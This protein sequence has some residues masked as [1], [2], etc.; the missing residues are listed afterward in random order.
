[1]LSLNALVSFQN[2]AN[3]VPS[4]DAPSTG[5]LQSPD[6]WTSLDGTPIKSGWSF[7]DG[8]IHLSQTSAD[9]T[10]LA[11]GHIITTDEFEDFDLEFE[12]KIGKNGNSG[13][14]YMVQRYDD[15]HLGI[16]YQI[17]DD[18]GLHRVEPKNSTGA[19]YDLYAPVPDKPLKPAGEWNRSRIVVQ[20]SQIQHWLNGRLI[21]TATMHDQEW[22]DRIAASKFHDVPGFCK[23]RRGRLMLTDHGSDAWYRIISFR[24]ASTSKNP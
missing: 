14:K 4:V 8:L 7:Q 9:Q 24:H 12:W 1:M 11:G 22:Q 10:E 15:R 20:N 19:L 5:H 13:I 3:T 23:S 6:H 21:A 17:Y 18:D 2:A 16:E